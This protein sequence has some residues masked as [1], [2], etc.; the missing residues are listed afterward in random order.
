M[1]IHRVEFFL[2]KPV[3]QT[4]WEKLEHDMNEA[5]VEHVNWQ[6]VVRHL[7]NDPCTTASAQE[8]LQGA[9][10]GSR[11]EMI[12]VIAMVF[13]CEDGGASAS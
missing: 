13:T 8:H 6:A 11:F 12:K 9:R 7:S 10:K 2:P 1:V 5:R 4:H 3:E